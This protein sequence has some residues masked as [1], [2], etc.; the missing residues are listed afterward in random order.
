MQVED[1]LELFEFNQEPWPGISV[2]STPWHTP[3]SVS[4]VIPDGTSKLVF[5]GDALIHRVLSIEN[6]WMPLRSDIIPEATTAG[7]YALL[8]TIV[9]ERWQLMGG[10]VS[11]PGLLYV[12]HEGVNYRTTASGYKGS[13]GSMMVCA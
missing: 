12:D 8:D 11:F 7:R 1:R 6:P 3:G 9:R 5:T 13:D 10:H 2:V 4:Y